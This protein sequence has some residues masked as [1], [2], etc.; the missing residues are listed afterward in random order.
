MP[1]P[2]YEEVRSLFC[3]SA[4]SLLR[5]VF[6]W[7][8]FLIPAASLLADTPPNDNFADRTPLAG[9]PVSTPAVAL[10]SATREPGEPG[11]NDPRNQSKRC[12]PPEGTPPG[13]RGQRRGVPGSR[14]LHGDGV[15]EPDIDSWR[16]HPI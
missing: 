12:G 14:G 3:E 2:M 11:H 15:N 8:C 10:Y 1:L 13:G 4:R 6:R 5:S 7:F 16:N 9:L